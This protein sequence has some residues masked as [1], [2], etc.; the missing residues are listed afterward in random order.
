MGI[1]LRKYRI[2]IKFNIGKINDYQRYTELWWFDTRILFP[3]EVKYKYV[4]YYA[5]ICI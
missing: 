4:G 3:S 1:N 2:Y 5:N